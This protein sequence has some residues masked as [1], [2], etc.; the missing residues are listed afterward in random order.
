MPSLFLLKVMLN[1]TPTILNEIKLGQ[2][3]KFPFLWSEKAQHQQHF[4]YKSKADKKICHAFPG[5]FRH[6][7]E[8][9]VGKTMGK[10][11]LFH[12]QQ[13]KI[14]EWWCSKESTDPPITSDLDDRKRYKSGKVTKYM[15]HVDVKDFCQPF[16]VCSYDQICRWRTQC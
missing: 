16:H 9:R 5:M 15:G 3:W 2:C 6:R 12:K 1:K 10:H 14:V 7:K 11:Q 4:C 8:N 13:G